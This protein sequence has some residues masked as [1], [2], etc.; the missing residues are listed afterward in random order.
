MLAAP[1]LSSAQTCLGLPGFETRLVH[2]NMS[3]ESA[4][5]ASAWAAGIGAGRAGGWFA[6][7]GVGQASFEGIEERATLGFL[8]LG[9]QVK[10]GRAQACPIAGGFYGTGPDDPII[11]LRVESM[12]VTAGVAL[13]A[14]FGR[15]AAQFVP[16]ASVRYEYLSQSVEQQGFGSILDTYHSGLLDV[17][18]ALVLWDR[19][20][21]QPVLHLPFAAEGENP[22]YGVFASIAIR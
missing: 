12:G 14:A 13:G 2:F 16:N 18:L 6:N 19:L 17:G 22:S 3:R 7:A 1:Q 21:V 4:D 11:G 10:V 20:S 5:S 8:E 9:R 15:G